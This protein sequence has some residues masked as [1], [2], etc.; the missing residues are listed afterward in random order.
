[1][2]M[3]PDCVVK[4]LEDTMETV[5][6]HI[7]VLR[8]LDHYV[9][10]YEMPVGIEFHDVSTSGRDMNW[11]A[12]SFSILGVD[13][14]LYTEHDYREASFL[15]DD[16]DQENGQVVVVNLLLHGPTSGRQAVQQIE[17]S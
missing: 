6:T 14:Y 13:H 5:N 2:Q 3:P 7:P 8:P 15:M 4:L 11:E 10:Y 9:A 17:T 12:V 16:G 1:M